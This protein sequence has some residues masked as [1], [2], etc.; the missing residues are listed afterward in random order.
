MKRYFYKASFNSHRGRCIR[1]FIAKGNKAV[2][3]TSE[4]VEK[5]GAKSYT[6]TPGGLFPGVGIGSLVFDTI[7]DL[8]KYESI[9][10]GE[11]IPNTKSSEGEVIAKMISK[12][13]SISAMDFRVA[14]GIPLNIF[15]TPQWFV[16]KEDIYISS[17][18]PMGNDYITILQHE[19][20][21]KKEKF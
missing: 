8:R 5:L 9:G 13:P 20:D 16:Y 2:K 19:F 14:F 10:K 15:K 18:Y 1:D 21:T 4:L 7:P 12:L 11:F 17:P 3:A 6:D